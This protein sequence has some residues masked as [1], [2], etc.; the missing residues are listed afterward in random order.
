MAELRVEQP[1]VSRLNEIWAMNFVPDAF[2]NGRRFRALAVVDADTW[3]C[4]AS[5]T[6]QGKKGEAV[7]TVT[8]RL[9]FQRGTAPTKISVDNGP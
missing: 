4:L 6:D 1:L 2:F 7:G 9:T 8:E 3:E 5:Y